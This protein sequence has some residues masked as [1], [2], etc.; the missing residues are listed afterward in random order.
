MCVAQPA[1]GI[2]VARFQL[3]DQLPGIIAGFPSLLGPLNVDGPYSSVSRRTTIGTPFPP[4]LFSHE[5]CDHQGSRT[6]GV[7]RAALS[8]P[9]V[10]TQSYHFVPSS[11][12][13]HA[14][15]NAHQAAIQ[16]AKGRPSRSNHPG[17]PTSI[18][19]DAHQDQTDMVVHHPDDAVRFVDVHGVA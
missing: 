2:G 6:Q 14:A 15:S 8:N 18:N 9:A 10:I 13:W 17:Q 7:A 4:V 3:L 19:A 12:G 11:S 1:V 16:R 5:S